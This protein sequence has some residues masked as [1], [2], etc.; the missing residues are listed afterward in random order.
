MLWCVVTRILLGES[1]TSARFQRHLALFA[2]VHFSSG[3]DPVLLLLIL[4][5][6]PPSGRR[7]MRICFAVVFFLFFLLFF[8]STKTMRQPFSGTAERIFMKLSPNDG[9][10]NVVWNVVPPLGE[11]RAAAWRMANVDAL[12]NLRYDSFAI[13]RGRQR[14][15]RYTTMSGRI[16][17]I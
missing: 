3:T 1:M 12:R 4:F 15:L 10:G 5:T 9:G 7:R 17:V 11:S 13:T 16:D 2:D 14:R 6:Q 8:P